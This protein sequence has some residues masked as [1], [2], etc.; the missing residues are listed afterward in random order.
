VKDVAQP[1]PGELA[2]CTAQ[3]PADAEGGAAYMRYAAAQ[4]RTHDA[5]APTTPEAAACCMAL[6]NGA[7]P[8]RGELAVTADAAW[9][10]RRWGCCTALLDD[11]AARRMSAARCT[12]WG[13]PVPPPLD[14]A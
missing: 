10:A 1:S 3:V 7:D 8:A 4:S 11:P 6:L 13:P 2:C 5:G 9:N 14:W 12:P